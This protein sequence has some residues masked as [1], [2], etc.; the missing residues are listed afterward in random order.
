V[1]IGSKN[2]DFISSQ[3]ISSISL[4]FGKII[5]RI[6]VFYHQSEATFPKNETN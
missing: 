3:P 4:F 1:K 6:T 2:H 5:F